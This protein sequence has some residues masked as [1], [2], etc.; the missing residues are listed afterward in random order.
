M[1]P[2]PVRHRNLIPHFLKEDLLPGLSRGRLSAVAHP[3]CP[4]D[5]DPGPGPLPQKRRQS[6]HEDVIAPVGFKVTVD[7]GDDLVLPRKHGPFRQGQAGRRVGHQMVRIHAIVADRD[8]FAERPREGVG[9]EGRGA[10]ACARHL[11]M[12]PV[13]EVLHPQPQ[14]LTAGRRAGELRIEILVGLSR[15]VEELA[16]EA[17][18]RF[19]P[20]VAQ[21][22]GLAP[23][24]VGQDYVR[25]Q[26]L[27][28]QPQGSF[29][30]GLGSQ[31]LGLEV[32]QPGMDLGRT[33][34]LDPVG[35][36]LHPLPAA[37]R[38]GPQGESCDLISTRR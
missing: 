15:L 9:L 22:H 26:P 12:D 36:E 20:D 21:E 37:A 34:A 17:Q 25:S 30:A 33:A 16:V 28:T 10:K 13:V 1:H 29:V 24:V 6:P 11:E 4:D 38:L 35:I 18:P 19:G 2:L 23:A 27:L 8:A 7:E 31:Q 3:V 5:Q 32:R 14:G